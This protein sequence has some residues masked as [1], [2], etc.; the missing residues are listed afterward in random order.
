MPMISDDMVANRS[1]SSANA[2]LADV[3]DKRLVE[4]G[5]FS[6][7]L[8]VTVAQ[9]DQYV[10]VPSS[11][12]SGVLS[13]GTATTVD[14]YIAAELAGPVGTAANTAVTNSGDLLNLTE[15]RDATTHSEVT[16][17][18]EKVFGLLQCSN[19]VADG[20]AIAANPSENI[21]LSFVTIDSSGT[22][23]LTALSTEVAVNIEFAVKSVVRLRNLPDFY[24]P[25]SPNPRPVLGGTSSITR[26][27]FSV[28][29]AYT[30]NEDITLATGAGATAGTSN[31]SANNNDTI[32]L[33]ANATAFNQSRGLVVQVN[34]LEME[35]GVDVV[36]VSSGSLRVVKPLHVGERFEVILFG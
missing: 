36:W 15:I 18:D 13:V 26:R 34:G 25:A 1:R 5:G 4:P 12:L 7:A 16:V 33:G 17:N 22:L 19:G 24:T 32:D 3:L 23:V 11:V 28:T 20:A 10:L 31:I 8:A 27:L 9:S 21:Q 29:A 35:K 14:G 6:E 2:T 30:A